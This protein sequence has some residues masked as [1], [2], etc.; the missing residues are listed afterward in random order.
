M[1]EV[2]LPSYVLGLVDDGDF[3]LLSSSLFQARHSSEN[4]ATVGD[5]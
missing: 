4:G 1:I 3:F 5:I 2:F